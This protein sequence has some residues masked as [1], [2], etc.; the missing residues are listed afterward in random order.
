MTRW[1]RPIFEIH[2]LRKSQNYLWNTNFIPRQAIAKIP[3]VLHST[4]TGDT[5]Y[6]VWLDVYNSMTRWKRPITNFLYLRYSQ[7]YLRNTNF[8]PGQAIAKNFFVPHS[9]YT[10][11]TQYRVWFDLDNSMTRWKRPIFEIHYLRKSQIYLW[12]TDFIPR[13]AI[14]KVP[15]VLHSTS[16]G[17]TPYR[18]WLDVDNSM[19]RWKRP[20]TNFPYLRYSQTSL[21]NTNFFPGQA[22]AKNLFV[23]HFNYTGHT[24][25]WIRFDLGNSMTRCKRPILEIH[26]SRNSQNYLWNTNFFPRQAIAKLFLYYTIPIQGILNTEFGSIWTTPW[27]VE[28]DLLLIFLIC[29]IRKLPC[30]IP[31]FFLGKL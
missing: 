28:K 19:T 11:H 2:Y 16:T 10:R 22:I 8:F 25:Y 9:N 1:K 31:T 14:A 7:T 18:V 21:R 5:P 26:N 4:H 29:D 24:Q 17:D 23:Q 20:I 30:E 12:N 27:P 15:F 13:Q 3:F 6:R